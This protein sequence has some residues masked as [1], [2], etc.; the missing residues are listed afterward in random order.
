MGRQTWGGNSSEFASE[1]SGEI[2]VIEIN[3]D[4]FYGF[5][6][7]REDGSVVSWGNL[8]QPNNISNLSGE[9]DVIELI[10]HEVLIF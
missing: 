5:A 2:D 9:I 4:S 3:S 10:A 7:L 6:A 1:L 8:E